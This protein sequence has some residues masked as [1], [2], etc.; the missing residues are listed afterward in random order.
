MQ[1][2]K[3]GRST[4]KLSPTR[5]V[6]ELQAKLAKCT[7]KHKRPTIA[8]ER[9]SYPQFTPGQS[10]ADYVTAFYGLNSLGSPKQ[11]F[12]EL[13]TDP[14]TLYTG[15]DSHVIVDDEQS[16]QDAPE[17][18][19]ACAV[20]P[21]ANDR[22]TGP[23]RPAAG[24]SV[25]YMEPEAFDAMAAAL[26]AMTPT[27]RAALRL[28]EITNGS[29]PA[30]V[31]PHW[32][33]VRAVYRTHCVTAKRA[34]DIAGIGAGFGGG[35]DWLAREESGM[36]ALR[37]RGAER[38]PA[39][40]LLRARVAAAMRAERAAARATHAPLPTQSH[41][42]ADPPATQSVTAREPDALPALVRD[43]LARMLRGES[44]ES[45][46]AWVWSGAEYAKRERVDSWLV[47]NG[48]SLAQLVGGTGETRFRC[49]VDMEHSSAR[50]A[51][52]FAG[53]SN[54]DLRKY[55]DGCHASRDYSADFEEAARELND[56]AGAVVVPPTHADVLRE[57]AARIVRPNP[58]RD[59]QS[60]QTRAEVAAELIA[61]ADAAD[62][63][64]RAQRHAAPVFSEY[65]YARRTG[66]T[67]VATCQGQGG[68]KSLAG[69]IAE[70]CG[71]RWVNR[72]H[73]YVGTPKQAERLRALFAE[74]TVAPSSKSVPVILWSEF[75]QAYQRTRAAMARPRTPFLRIPAGDPRLRIPAQ[76]VPVYLLQ[77]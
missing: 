44:L 9:R 40:H 18:V 1:T 74:R 7:G 27:E 14:C 58:H 54:A 73:G 53:M 69:F 66:R 6:G 3:I 45:A 72:A 26:Q 36:N 4:Y 29:A 30:E 32:M 63:A 37:L 76:F 68:W 71:M 31:W 42:E 28:G 75:A 38:T 5:N 17:A 70:E 48:H 20:A 13:N 34:R 57:R 59:E 41:V 49:L 52:G 39:A 67:I 50:N 47:R 43:A 23:V 60:N 21:E 51:S 15:E 22:A 19:Q 25:T 62:A 55:I 77:A 46:C 10:T 33:P 56:R 35:N 11:L 12:P 65:R 24:G 8:K 64:A 16:P 2:L 61:E